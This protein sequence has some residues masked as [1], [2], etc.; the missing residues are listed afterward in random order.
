[1]DCFGDPKHI[2]KV[3]TDIQDHKC[4]WLLVTAMGIANPAQRQVIDT[5]L[6]HDEPEHIQA[7]KDLYLELGLVKIF[8]KFE[9]DS[10]AEIVQSIEKSKDILPP[11]LFT[12]ILDKIHRRT[13]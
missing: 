13:Y 7:I 9:D 3:G 11:I 2:G 8:D 12:K 5:H 1:L 6:G 4:T 10:K